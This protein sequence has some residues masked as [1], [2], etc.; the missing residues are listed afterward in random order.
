M[1]QMTHDRREL[2]TD[3]GVISVVGGYAAF[4]TLWILFSDRAVEALFHDPQAIIR[5]SIL[6]G[7]VF[8]AVTSLLLYALVRRLVGRL[9][10][11][12][13]REIAAYA[14]RQRSLEL[15]S[16]IADN[17]D[18]AIFAKDRDGR[19]LLFN[20][21]A[22]RFVGKSADDV[23]GRDDS[24]LFPAEQAALLAAIGRRVMASGEIE[25][26]E[27]ALATPDGARVFLAT[28]G[29]LRDREGRIYGTF[30]ISRDITVIKEAQAGL[31]D[32]EDRLRLLITHAPAALAMFDRDMRYLVASRRWCEDFGLGQ[33]DVTG[34]SHYEIFPDLPDRFRQIHRRGLSGEVISEKSD[35]FERADGT[36]HWLRWEMRPWYGREGAVGGIVIFSEDITEQKQREA[37][38]ADSEY[39]YRQL[40]ENSTDWVWTMDMSGRHT[41]TNTRGLRWLGLSWEAF[42]AA[43][44]A[45]LV[46]PDDHGLLAET[47]RR[48]C[49]QRTGWQGVLLRWRTREGNYLSIE[50]NASPMMDATGSLI[51]FQGVDRDVTA[52][53]Q[54]EQELALHREHLEELVRQR[55]HQLEAAQTRAEAASIAKSAFLANMSHEI[56]TPLNAITGMAHLI[57]RAGLPADQ[58]DRFDKLER[59][60]HHLLEIINAIL[61]LSKIE[62]GKFVLEEVPFR[63]DELVDGVSAIV[64][65]AAKAKH[66]RLAKDVEPTPHIL[67]GDRTRLQQVFLNYAT[68][69][70]KF[71]DA[72]EITLR[73]RIAEDSLDAVVVRLEVSD[74]GPGIEPDAIPRLFSSFEQADNSITRRYGGTGLGLAITRKIAELMGG[75]VGVESVAGQG[76]TFWMTVR[77]MKGRD[78]ERQEATSDSEAAENQVRQ[79][80]GARV[81]VVEDEA[82]NREV[83]AVLLEEAG[84]R[85]DAANDGEEAV[86]LAAAT[87]YSAILMDMQMPVMDGLEATRR[88]RAIPGRAEVPIIA[89]TANVF[90]EDR[91][92]CLAAGMNDFLSKPVAPGLLYEVLA[93]WLRR[94]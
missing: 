3:R 31:R 13:A 59:A 84:L 36:V 47:F 4:A 2:P 79:F 71:T 55:T 30:G 77:L 78:A 72:G 27:E 7:W 92:R 10:A 76:S 45:E 82:V 67:L 42:L 90:A 64:S 22:A 83:A 39:R 73:A 19:Y 6:K 33:A 25:T 56:R 75:R 1:Q 32:S 37:A 28:K 70:I 38:L 80:K 62:A 8:V 53:I 91:I 34:Q 21:A 16:A 86:R 23:I 54:V 17:S 52:R 63:I 57:R 14:D 26:N 51:G 49:E 69:A 18:D 29:P 44:P 5:A 20:P 24:A 12:H 94:H 61:D 88:I 65:H 48:A 15:L 93:K 68:N 50:S 74:T 66:I 85:V 60:G 11:A 35:R 89:M 40:A 58:I 81:L 46:H 87:A 43:D 41:Y 9:A